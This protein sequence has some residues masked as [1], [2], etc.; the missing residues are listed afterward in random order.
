MNEE[1][2]AHNQKENERN[3]LYE[4]LDLREKESQFNMKENR[5]H[6]KKNGKI[7]HQSC[8]HIYMYIYT[9]V[10]FRL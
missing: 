9:F 4:F 5:I 6:K 10:L 2:M 3:R 1:N 8:F 7:H